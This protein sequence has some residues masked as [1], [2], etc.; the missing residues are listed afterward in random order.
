[1]L[2]LEKILLAFYNILQRY[3]SAIAWLTGLIE[4]LKLCYS[5][6]GLFSFRETSVNNL[7]LKSKS[8]Y[9]CIFLPSYSSITS[10]PLI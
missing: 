5:L 9:W 10:T 3:F 4:G 7:F 6:R 1:M 2:F 8:K